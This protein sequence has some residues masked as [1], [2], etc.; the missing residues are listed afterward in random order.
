MA[1][2]QA[3]RLFTRSEVGLGPAAL[4]AVPRLSYGAVSACST[5]GMAYAP[6]STDC[7]GQ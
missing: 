4:G 6:F 3:A 1:M 5:G 7:S 2:Q